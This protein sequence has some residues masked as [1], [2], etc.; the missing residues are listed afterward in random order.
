MRFSTDYATSDM[1]KVDIT[2]SNGVMLGETQL[3]YTSW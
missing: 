3:V 2:S 1:K